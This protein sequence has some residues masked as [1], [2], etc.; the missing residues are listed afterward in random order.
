MRTFLRLFLL[1][2]VLEFGA[3]YILYGLE[4]VSR[5]T[6]QHHV[7]NNY[8][9]SFCSTINHHSNVLSPF[10]ILEKNG[11]EEIEEEDSERKSGYQYLNTS[12]F[13]D[14]NI[15]Y[16]KIWRRF[17]I[18]SFLFNIPLFIIF[19]SWKFHI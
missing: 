10:D 15:L 5:T 1:A 11:E 13:T 9:N 12:N 17:Q 3:I 16:T 6:S 7:E 18:S 14:Y 8:D 4:I 19:H 2:I